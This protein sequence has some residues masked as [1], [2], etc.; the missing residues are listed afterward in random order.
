M[1]FLTRKQ[2]PRKHSYNQPCQKG[3]FSAFNIMQI[4]CTSVF[5]KL[6]KLYFRKV[7]SMEEFIGNWLTWYKV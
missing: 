2:I 3:Y 4:L 7:N 6:S 1:S 5:V